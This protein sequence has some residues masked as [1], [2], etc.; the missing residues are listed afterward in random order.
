MK[1]KLDFLPNKLNKYSIRRFTV[2]TASI[3]VGSTLLFGIGNEAHAA[4]EHQKSNTTENVADSNA[5]EAPTKEEA[6][7]N[8]ATSEAPTKE[9]VPSNEATSEAPTK[10][11]APSNEATSEAPTK[12]EA[13][14]NEAT[15]EASTKEEAPAAEETDK[16]TEE[17][18]KTEETDKATTEEAP[19]VEETSKAA[20]EEA[21]KAEE[22]DKATEEAPK[23][24]ETSKAATEKAPKA[25]ETNKVETEEAPAAEETNKAATEETP[26][27]EDTNAKSNSN[28]QPS[29]TERTQ[30]VDTVAKDLY[31]KSEVTEAEK[32]EIEKV[33]PK[34]I[35]NLSNE[36]IKKIALS[37]VLKETANKENAQPRATF[38]SVSSNARTTNVN[39]SA[40]ALR[41][42]AQD[43]VTKKGT[44]NFTAHGDIIHKTYKEEFPNEGK[45][46]AFNTN[47]NPDTGTK[48][49]LEY[50]DK[51]DFN[52]D[53]TITVP[54]ANNNQGNTTGADGWGFMFTQGNGQ[55]FLNQGGILRDKGMANASGFKIDTAYNNVNGKVDKLDADK[56]NNLS[57]IG[58]AKVGYGTFVKNGAD[59][60]TNQ[61]GQNAL[62]TKDKPVNKIIYADNTTNHLDGQFHGQRLNDVVLNYDA[63]TSTITATYAG[64]TWKATTDDL[65][66]DKSQKYN[67]LITS[68]HMQN[69]YSNGIMRTNLEGVTITT[70]QADLIDDVEVT[71]QPIPHKTIRE[72]DPTLEPGSPDVIV[73]K[74]EDGEKT[75]TTPT[76]VDPDTGD[77]VER[78][79]PTTEVTKNPVDEIVHFAP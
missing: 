19:A 20:T 37:E 57:Q 13:P 71:K 14:S 36:E 77:V 41:A 79:E 62:N 18:P 43:T 42:A 68:S 48:G 8:E 12:E 50:N 76:K 21:P 27:V 29:E 55:D 1:K 44:G 23:T 25:E 58:A 49:A 56:T 6:P 51:I 67:F 40:T 5:S 17:A 34:D 39:Y 15:S 73:Q 11:E 3:L 78:G 72:F 74:G 7:S 26:A 4:E 54:V 60:V 64:K 24:E 45:L 75:T 46:T 32:A 65:G 22:T 53:F 10:E 33:L 70:P 16:A 28:A 66:I 35:S 61:V 38:R 30:V 9:E 47:F 69:R 31:K 59:G 52:K 2:G 63:A